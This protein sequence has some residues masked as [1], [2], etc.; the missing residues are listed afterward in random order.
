MTAS[1]LSLFLTS[2]VVAY[3]RSARAND[4]NALAST[5][6]PSS[7]KEQVIASALRR[8]DSRSFASYFDPLAVTTDPDLSGGVEGSPIKGVIL[9]YCKP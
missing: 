7:P 4:S 9:I 8:T 3:A 6:S 2:S 1:N 5:G